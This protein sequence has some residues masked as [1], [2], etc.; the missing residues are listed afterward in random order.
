MSNRS[1]K[2]LILYE[3]QYLRLK[4]KKYRTRFPEVMSYSALIVA[5]GHEKAVAQKHCPVDIFLF[6]F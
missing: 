3:L 4:N 5:E 1:W 2:H 6:Y